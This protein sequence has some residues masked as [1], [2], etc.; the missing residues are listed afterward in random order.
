[1]LVVWSPWQVCIQGR[2]C[3]SYSYSN[4]CSVEGQVKGRRT[5]YSGSGGR[6]W[7]ESSRAGAW[8]GSVGAPR[9]LGTSYSAERRDGGG[10]GSHSF[11]RGSR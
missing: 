2:R 8:I 7:L 5:S 10:E 11:V 9:G 3:F 6:H 4:P 1:M